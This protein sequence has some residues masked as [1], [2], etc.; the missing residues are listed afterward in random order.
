MQTEV[1]GY[2]AYIFILLSIS[3]L[4][5]HTIDEKLSVIFSLGYTMSFEDEPNLI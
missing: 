1:L 2:V 5:F 3:A 4:S